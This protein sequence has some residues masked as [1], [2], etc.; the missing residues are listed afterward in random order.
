MPPNLHVWEMFIK[1]EEIKEL[2]QKMVLMERTPW[3]ITQCF[4]TKMLGYLKKE[5]KVNG[6]L[7][8]LVKF[9]VG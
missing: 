5:Q 3:I 8:I 6:P 4:Y 7:K 2:L 1:P 9:L